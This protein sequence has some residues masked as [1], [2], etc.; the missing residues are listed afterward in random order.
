V[1]PNLFSSYNLAK[2]PIEARYLFIGLFCEADDHGYLI[3][4]PKRIAGAIFP[5]DDRV[6]E[7]KVDGWLNQLQSVGSIL[8]Y[9]YGDGRYI[10]LPEWETHQRVSHA[11]PTTLPQVSC[12]SLEEFRSLAGAARESFRPE[13]NGKGN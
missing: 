9:E 3:D 1:K 2:V 10:V 12:V 4:S 11:L 7:K 5:H 8:R 13:L 6:T